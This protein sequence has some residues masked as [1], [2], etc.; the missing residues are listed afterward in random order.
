VRVCVCVDRVV[1]RLTEL[2]R[3]H[4]RDR[5]RRT[6]TTNNTLWCGV[7]E[8]VKKRRRERLEARVS[9]VERWAFWLVCARCSRRVTLAPPNAN[10][11]L[12]P[13]LLA[14]PFGPILS[15]RP[16][17]ALAH[18][19]TH[20]LRAPAPILCLRMAR[21][22]AGT[23]HRFCSDPA[24]RAPFEGSRLCVALRGRDRRRRRLAGRRKALWGHDGRTTAPH[25]RVAWWDKAETLTLWT[26]TN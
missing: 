8:S 25:G 12:L 9:S 13:P 6:G 10:I 15:A 3:I 26:T 4:H 14:I 17:L 21:T 7:S 16:T 19:P 20:T 24:A 1:R 5:S 22:D 11:H 23:L 2:T 18:V